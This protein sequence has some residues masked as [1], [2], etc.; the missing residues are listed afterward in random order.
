MGNT[1][2]VYSNGK[3]VK[4]M[5]RAK[6]FGYQPSITIHAVGLS[7]KKA[8]EIVELSRRLYPPNDEIRRYAVLALNHFVDLSTDDCVFLE[9]LAHIDRPVDLSPMLRVCSELLAGTA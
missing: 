2:I 9:G 4:Q 6:F 1:H 7:G 3:G 5:T 8:D